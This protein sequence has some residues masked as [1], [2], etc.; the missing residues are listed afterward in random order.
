MSYLNEFE[1][2]KKT[3]L[4]AGQLLLDSEID[5]SIISA[6][7]H[8][9]KIAADKLVEEYILDQLTTH[10]KLPILSEESGA[11]K[12]F[13]ESGSYWIVD[14]IDG[15]MNFKNDLPLYCVSI[16]LWSE[17]APVFGFIYDPCR[18]E[19][20]YNDLNGKVFLNDK[21]IVLK[22]ILLKNQAVLATG[23]PLSFEYGNIEKYKELAKDVQ[24][25]KKI[26][27]LGTAALSLA[28]TA[29]GRV[30]A[31]KESN[32][33]LWDIAAGLAIVNVLKSSTISYTKNEKIDWTYDVHVTNHL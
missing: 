19:L 15:S 22:K 28:W 18:K 5:D 9:I 12:N 20:I 25:Y 3:I 7:G 6:E 33:K 8:D 1:L 29:I 17:K 23:F 11:T 32:I 21:E 16:A 26:R 13:S 27:M 2:A 24:E 4:N 30:N 31:Y 10:S 14:P